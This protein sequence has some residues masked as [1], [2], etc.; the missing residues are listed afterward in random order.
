[1]ARDMLLATPDEVLTRIDLEVQ[2]STSRIAAAAE[3]APPPPPPPP[4]PAQALPSQPRGPSALQLE[5]NEAKR[6]LEEM[7]LQVEE[8]TRQNAALTTL[9]VGQLGARRNLPL[10][11]HAQVPVAGCSWRPPGAAIAPPPASAAAPRGPSAA[12]PSTS[13][14]PAAAKS[15][16]SDPL[17]KLK[18]R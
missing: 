6:K 18:K 11:Q 4:P 5:L 17:A 13:F 8:V 1:M 10:P 9:N 15:K 2:A 14:P 7:R 3:A 16:K 12:G